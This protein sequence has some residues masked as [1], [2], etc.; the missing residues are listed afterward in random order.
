[1][2]RDG[3]QWAAEC[4]RCTIIGNALLDKPAVAPGAELILDL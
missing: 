3:G 1:M 4:G 2:K